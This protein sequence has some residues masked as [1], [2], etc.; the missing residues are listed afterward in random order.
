VD[1]L[2]GVLDVGAGACLVIGWRADSLL[3]TA[4]AP[5]LAAV[6]LVINR[7]QPTKRRPIRRSRP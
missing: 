2:P 6:A 1:G 5:V 3:I 7:R 4:L